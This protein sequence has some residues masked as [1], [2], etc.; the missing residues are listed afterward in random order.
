MVIGNVRHKINVSNE[1]EVLAKKDEEVA[2]YLKKIKEYRHSMY[3]FVQ[4]MEK[5]IR[6][7]IFTL[8]NPNLEYFRK[9]NQNHSIDNAVEFLIEII[10]PDKN[11]QQQIKNQLNKYVLQDINFRQLHNNLRYPFYSLKYNS[12]SCVDFN[13]EDCEV[14]EKKLNELKNYL[15]QLQRL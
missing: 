4:A 10:S 5:N 12:Y 7:K 2:L 9:K 1:Y 6:S 3:F 15:N 13:Q 14:I 8:V 11:I